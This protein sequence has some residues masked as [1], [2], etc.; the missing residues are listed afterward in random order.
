MHFGVARV[1]INDF[2]QNRLFLVYSKVF[3]SSDKVEPPLPQGFRII[4]G[5]AVLLQLSP[6]IPKR[7]VR[8]VG[9]EE[10]D[11]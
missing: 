10:K 8:A 2:S 9:L 1:Y 6:G 11:S 7:L 5:F 4:L 3:R